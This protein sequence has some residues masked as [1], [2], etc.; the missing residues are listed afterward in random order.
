MY[1]V[2]VSTPITHVYYLFFSRP[3]LSAVVQPTSSKFA[4][5]LETYPQ[6][7]ICYAS[8]LEVTPKRCEGKNIAYF[9]EDDNNKITIRWTYTII[10]VPQN[11]FFWVFVL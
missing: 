4:T 3:T 8:F 2:A 10:N 1:S 7:K 9:S 6:Y 5:E 11:T